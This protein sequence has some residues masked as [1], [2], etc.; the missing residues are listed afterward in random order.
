[1]RQDK[2]KIRLIIMKFSGKK[3]PLSGQ[4]QIPY[5][6]IFLALILQ[7]VPNWEQSVLL[8]QYAYKLIAFCESQTIGATVE[9]FGVFGVTVTVK[10][11]LTRKL[12]SFLL[13]D[14][15][16]IGSE[17][18]AWN[19]DKKD[20]VTMLGG[21][22]ESDVV[23]RPAKVN[24]K[25]VV[26]VLDWRDDSGDVMKLSTVVEIT[27][28][29]VD[30]VVVIVENVF[31]LLLFILISLAISSAMLIVLIR[32]PTF[33]IITSYIIELT[34]IKLK[35]FRFFNGATIT[36]IGDSTDHLSDHISN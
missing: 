5:P 30:W 11:R 7:T 28:V 25:G 9:T 27:V 36:S 17:E 29:N 35:N 24:D 34:V 32:S 4:T 13:V 26:T 19:A 8:K 3:I 10:K 2:K 6:S 31:V 16:D 23:K 18:K 1:M 21:S 33:G 14:V 12:P 15:E 22:E 20:V